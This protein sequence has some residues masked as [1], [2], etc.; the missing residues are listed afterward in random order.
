MSR[1]HPEVARKSS[2]EI[3]TFKSYWHEAFSI[4]KKRR[5]CDSMYCNFQCLR[6]LI[7]C[8]TMSEVTWQV[9]T[10]KQRH[11]LSKWFTRCSKYSNR[12]QVNYRISGLRDNRPL[13]I[14]RILFVCPPKFCISIVSR[15]SWDLQWSQEKIKTIL[16]QNLGGQIK[17]IMVFSEVAYSSWRWRRNTSKRS[18]EA[19]NTSRYSMIRA[20]MQAECDQT[21]ITM[22]VAV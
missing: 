17:S 20:V 5:G 9:L 13:R 19:E 7:S 22:G 4:F 10:N 1:K 14:L 3:A 16:M 6:V 12:P 2:H 8:I 18:C 15:F 21:K 11:A